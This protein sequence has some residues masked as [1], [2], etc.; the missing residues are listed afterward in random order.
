MQEV[1]LVEW[2]NKETF[3][4]KSLPE[5]TVIKGIG[6]VKISDDAEFAVAKNG[7]LEFRKNTSYHHPDSDTWVK[8]SWCFTDFPKGG[9]EV[10]WER[11]T[12]GVVKE[13]TPE[14]IKGLIEKDKM[15][16]YKIK[17]KNG[18]ESKEVQKLLFGLGCQWRSAD[19][20]YQ[21]MGIYPSYI[22]CING[23]LTYGVKPYYEHHQLETQEITL[24]VLREI[25]QEKQ[26]ASHNKISTQLIE[27]RTNIFNKLLQGVKFQYRYND[28]GQWHNLT[29]KSIGHLMKSN[30]TVRE[31]PQKPVIDG[32][33]MDKEAAIK[34]IEKHY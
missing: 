32:I 11:E 5:G 17:V 9:W 24:T 7:V 31:K 6:W 23:L 2:L 25:L 10:V 14:V 21:T 29:D 15:N 20:N 16:N 28:A 19:Q 26:T 4:V 22:F 1:K 3:E 33:E 12:T 18:V 34:Y 27:D 13:Q 8:A 30:V